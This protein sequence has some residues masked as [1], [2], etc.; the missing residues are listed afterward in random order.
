M[1]VFCSV[2]QYSSA[3]HWERTPQT[4]RQLWAGW[5]SSGPQRQETAGT[6]GWVKSP[7]KSTT[8]MCF[9]AWIS[10]IQSIG[11][12][13][14]LVAIWRV[15]FSPTRNSLPLLL[16]AGCNCA[17]AKLTRPRHRFNQLRCHVNIR[18]VRISI[19]IGDISFFKP[20]IPH[21]V[22][23]AASAETDAHQNRLLFHFSNSKKTKQQWK[24]MLLCQLIHDLL[25]FR[26]HVRS[27]QV[28]PILQANLP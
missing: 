17:T 24:A 11:I 5:R 10:K 16:R 2:C 1:Q 18:T 6:I 25:E 19:H 9:V 28:R 21:Y 8:P 20:T 7:E 22:M 14:N 23:V 3:R 26:N 27:E 13:W 15:R 12:Y 4:R